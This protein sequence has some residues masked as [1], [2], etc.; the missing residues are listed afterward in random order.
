MTT[1]SCRLPHGYDVDEQI[2]YPTQRSPE[3]SYET[4]ECSAA[5]T[6]KHNTPGPMG[7][8]DKA[9]QKQNLCSL[10]QYQQRTLASTNQARHII[11]TVCNEIDK[12]SELKGAGVIL[13]LPESD[14]ILVRE[15][16][17]AS[18][19][20]T[21]VKIIVEVKTSMPPLERSWWQRWN[22]VILNCG[23]AVVSWGA[24]ALSSAAEV[25]SV[26]AATPLVVLSW[27]AATATT[28][29]CGLAIAKESS[30]DFAEYIQSDDGEWINTADIV[31]DIV[32]LAGGISGAKNAIS[33][34][35]K[36][37]SKSKYAAQLGKVPKGSLM[38]HLQRLEKLD[39]DISYFNGAVKQ[40]VATGKV[41]DPAA[42]GLSNNIVK[43]ALPM[44]TK[45]LNK[46]MLAGLGDAI[47]GT[48]ATISSSYGGAG[49]EN[50]GLVKTTIQFLQ[51]P[52]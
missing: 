52:L 35:S 24:V 37:L 10:P 18:Q 9:A 36:L 39:A 22:G 19:L 50:F 2:C 48:M 13:H 29:Q 31:L 28:A 21:Y 30:D 1:N 33:S 43:R 26:G 8:N 45:S 46:E 20:G 27:T 40:L 34:G 6:L 32:S 25:P 38:K 14:P 5:P 17:H 47:S 23:G 3:G 15:S 41:A 4:L 49:S 42:R 11:A 51:D 44:I 7:I 12:R 16:D